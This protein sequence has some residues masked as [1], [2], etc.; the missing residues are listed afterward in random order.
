[1]E[2][3]SVFEKPWWLD[4][5]APDSWHDLTVMEDNKIIARWPIVTNGNR[6]AMP[7][8][9]QTLGFWISDDVIKSDPFYNKRKKIINCL[10]DQIPADKSIKISLDHNADYFLPF[11]W[12]NFII[13]PRISYRFSNLS[14][15]DNIYNG[16][17]NNVKRNIKSAAK[18]VIVENSEDIEHL[19]ILLEKTFLLQKRKYPF[20]KEL[21]RKIFRASQVH[22]SSSLLYAKDNE[23]NIHSGTLL[24]YDNKVCY[25]LLVGTDPKYRSSGANT[26]LIWEGIKFASQVSKSFDFEGS[27]IEGIE[28]FYRQFGG[29]PVVYYEIRKQHFF[30]E[31]YELLKP[32]IKSIIGYKI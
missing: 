10:L 31:I 29:K 8:L 16:F 26:L 19:Q 27:M 17:N 4:V 12:K 23:G 14:N 7:P 18:K 22:K 5:V 6:I 24:L 20:S 3:N 13:K 25:Y 11:Y 30:L 32:K 28:N 21:V 9:T 2:C 15:I 1:M